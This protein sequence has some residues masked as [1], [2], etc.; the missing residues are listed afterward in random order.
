M[1][2]Q[3]NKLKEKLSHTRR[4]ASSE[5]QRKVSMEYHL[6]LQRKAE[7]MYFSIQR[8]MRDISKVAGMFTFPVLYNMDYLHVI[9]RI[10]LDTNRKA[11]Q[12]TIHLI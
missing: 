6:E 3:L 2:Q 12:L 5:R 7:I 11:E 8:R 9:E 4:R 10:V 1:Q